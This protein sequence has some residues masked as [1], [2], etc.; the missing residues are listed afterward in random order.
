M[1]GNNYENLKLTIMAGAK[2][3]I[4]VSLIVEEASYVMA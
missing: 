2:M 3:L 4:L 1:I